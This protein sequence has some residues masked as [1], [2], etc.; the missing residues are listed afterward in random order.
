[1]GMHMCQ[2]FYTVME[3]SLGLQRRNLDIDIT[4]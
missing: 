1:M 3:G 4:Q 2:Y